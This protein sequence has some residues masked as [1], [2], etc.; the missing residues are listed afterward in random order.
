METLAKVYEQVGID[1]FENAAPQIKEY[2][3]SIS[4][5]RTNSFESLSARKVELINREWRIGFDTFGYDRNEPEPSLRS[6]PV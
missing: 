1:G 4:G 6:L 2:L 3:E 5:Y